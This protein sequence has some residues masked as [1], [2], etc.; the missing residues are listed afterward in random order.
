[1]ND[2]V[3]KLTQKDDKKAYEFTKQIAAASVSS[4]E[5]Y[6]MIDDF[7]ALLSDDKSYIR[8]RAF[9]LCCSQAKWDK[10][11]KL[12]QYLSQLLPLFHD[13]KPTDV[14][15]CLNATKEIVVYRPEL[16]ESIKKEL[17]KIDLSKYKD[18]MVGLIEKDIGELKELIKE[19]Y[20]EA[21]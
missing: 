15:Q 12:K 7:A 19:T 2:I 9:I 11:G 10:D 4:S 21:K 20:L 18:S 3:E 8:T 5:Y 1:M 14:R 13:E 6:F 16:C 17:D